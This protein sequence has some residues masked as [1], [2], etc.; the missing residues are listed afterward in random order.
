MKIETVRRISV[1]RTQGQADDAGQFPAGMFLPCT[2]GVRHTARS[3]AARKA[4][5]HA[6]QHAPH[7]RHADEIREGIGQRQSRPDGAYVV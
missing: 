4:G 5:T 6:I 7:V 3:K 1:F 2:R